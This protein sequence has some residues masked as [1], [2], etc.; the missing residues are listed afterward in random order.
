MLAGTLLGIDAAAEIDQLPQRRAELGRLGCQ[1]FHLSITPAVQVPPAAA[2]GQEVQAAV[3]APLRLQ[4]RLA[5]ATGHAVP[6]RHRAGAEVGQQ[7]PGFVPGH[8]R[9]VPGH[10]RQ[11]PAVGIEGAD[12]E[13][14]AR[15]WLDKARAA[16]AWLILYTH[17]VSDTPSQFGC[18]PGA[19]ERLTAKAVLDEALDAYP[20][21][22]WDTAYGSAGT[23][24]AIGDVL[25]AA[26]WPAGVPPLDPVP[27]IVLI[28]PERASI[29]RT[30]AYC[31]SRK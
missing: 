22:R 21:D 10:Q 29:L 1:R 13:E 4:H 30:T 11:L 8:G 5:R 18:T 19:L 17:D 20:P 6:G 7:Q 9:V 28:L 31:V 12:G 25:V 2:V 27:A 23:V 14:T 3:G 16:N 15:Q 24:G 26:G